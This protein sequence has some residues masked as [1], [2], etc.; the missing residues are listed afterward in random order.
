MVGEH[1][2]GRVIRRLGS[3]P[4]LP[5]EIPLTAAGPEHV[6]AH[7]V[8]TRG[9]DRIDLG[10][11]LV[12]VVDHPSVQPAVDALAERQVGGLVRTC[13]VAVER[14][15]DVCGDCGHAGSDF[16]PA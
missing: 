4:S 15:G 3:P 16:R 2:H 7:D 10:A 6:A 5:L 1:E 14:N 11:V 13:G 8:G 12:G 9:G